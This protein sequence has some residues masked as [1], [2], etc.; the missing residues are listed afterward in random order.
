MH[1][2]DN[3]CPAGALNQRLKH[4]L[5]RNN[6]F[7]HESFHGVRRGHMQ[8]QHH[9]QGL[10]LEAV[11]DRALIKSRE[12]V[13]RYVDRGRH[14]A[15]IKRLRVPEDTTPFHKVN[16][17]VPKLSVSILLWSMHPEP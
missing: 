12:I 17:W 14:Q 6:I 3:A 4:H 2:T 1:G 15:R 8:H 13:Q 10:S 11:G 16:F 5:Q 9:L 7:N